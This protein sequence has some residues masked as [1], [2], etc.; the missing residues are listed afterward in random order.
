MKNKIKRLL[1][2]SG[3]YWSWRCWLLDWDSRL[4][5]LYNNKISTIIETIKMIASHLLSGLHQLWWCWLFDWD[6]RLNRL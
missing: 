1:H 6:S 5:H 3:L 2:L 4:S